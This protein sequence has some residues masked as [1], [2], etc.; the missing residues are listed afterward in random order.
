MRV[1]LSY[2]VEPNPA[3]RGWKTRYRY[4]SHGLRFEVKTATETDRQFRARINALARGEEQDHRSQSG[5][6]EWFLGPDLRSRGSV[7]SDIWTGTAADLADRGCIA[8][9]P[10]IG[11][12]RERHQLGRWNRKASLRVGG[13]HQHARGDDRPVHARSEPSYRAS[14]TPIGTSSRETLRRWRMCCFGTSSMGVVD[15]GCVS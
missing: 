12:W 3:R 2:F 13:Y 4:A 11:W 15:R 5:A 7:H 14:R 9:Y 1:T 8:V 10:V 6:E